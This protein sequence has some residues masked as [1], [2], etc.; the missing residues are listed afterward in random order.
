MTALPWVFDDGG[1]RASGFRGETGDCVV[2][3]IAIATGI[4]YRL[5]YGDLG[6]MMKADPV[7][8][9]LRTTSPRN[10]VTRKVYQEYLTT[11]HGW[12][13][14]PTM[15]IGQGCKVHLAVGELPTNIGPLIVRI[16]KHLSAV[17]DGEVRDLFDPNNRT[18][19][20]DAPVP[21]RCVYG[22]FHDPRRAT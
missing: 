6:I 9:K 8:R 5:V 11:R 20:D 17:V 1:R 4:D 13:W 12:H 10:G 19:R 16:S 7:L 21:D 2:R 14:V 22:Y 15:R 18:S 3:A